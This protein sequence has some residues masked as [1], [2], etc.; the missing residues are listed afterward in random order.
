MRALL[1]FD[2][3]KD[4]MNAHDACF[5]AAAALRAEHPEWEFDICPLTDGGEGF[6]RILT[7][8]AKGE[9][10][11]AQ[12]SGPKGEPVSA[13]FGLVP[14]QN[15]PAAARHRLALPIDTSDSATIAVI[16]MA[17]ASGLTLLPPHE[18]NPWKTSSYGT[19]ELMRNAALLNVGA[20]LLGIGGSATNDLGLG[21]LSALGLKFTGG[22][23]IFSPPIPERWSALDRI[24]GTVASDFPPI[25]VACDVTNPLLG[26]NGCAAIYGPQ[27]G[28]KSADLPRLEDLSRRV[29]QLLCAHCGISETIMH[30]PGAG[31]AGG[32]A[33]GLM[34]AT[35]AKLLSGFALT[36]DWF[37]L[38]ERIRSA[39]VILT[40]E[41]RYDDSSA[42]GKGPG[43]IVALATAAN[44]PSHV[45]AGSI[46][47][48]LA[49]P[50][51]LHPITPPAWKLDDALRATP[52]LLQASIRSVFRGAISPQS[53]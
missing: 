40:G 53:R 52:E 48:N 21:A 30:A 47:E 3:F 19:G 33:F 15:I 42:Q 11:T 22:G 27:K 50:A 25:R 35:G 44:R 39:D 29:A 2:K 8:S 31:A 23:E 9:F 49:S 34:A 24:R 4:A 14:L 1:A 43:A 6:A 13:A 16:E 41:G 7:E 37:G 5:N 45:F 38:P 46:P 51:N 20:I 32:I 10:H 18:R 17:S 28:L 12:V 36:S 26:P